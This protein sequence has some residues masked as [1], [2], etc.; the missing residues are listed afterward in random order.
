[1]PYG[2]AIAFEEA[3]QLPVFVRA[4]LWG[5]MT[6]LCIGI[7]VYCFMTL[8]KVGWDVFSLVAVPALLVALY[9]AAKG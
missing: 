1:M 8:S 3:F 2:W 9:M 7:P 4:I 5:L 6:A